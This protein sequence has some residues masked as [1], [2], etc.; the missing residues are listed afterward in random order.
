LLGNGF[1]VYSRF[2]VFR[3]FGAL[4]KERDRDRDRDREI[5]LELIG[6]EGRKEK[7][8]GGEYK[9]G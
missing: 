3:D 4:E 6:N 2:S 5:L 9:K 7:F 8:R 1:R